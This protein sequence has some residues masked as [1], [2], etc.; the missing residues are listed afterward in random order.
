[1]PAEYINA[2][3]QFFGINLE[4]Y[5]QIL[6]TYTDLIDNLI[7]AQ[8]TGNISEINRITQLLYQNADQSASAMA[9]LNPSFWN[10]S[11]WRPRLYNNLRYTIDESTTFLTGDYNANLDVFRSLL[12]LAE[13]TSGFFARGLFSYLMSRQP[14][15]QQYYYL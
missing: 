1:V 5:L 7:T 6:N 2:L 10:V 9:A 12:D 4:S 3:Q 15:T 8:Q 14:R 11:E 13:S